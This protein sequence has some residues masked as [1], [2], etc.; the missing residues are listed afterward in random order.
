MKV[1]E[2][3]AFQQIPLFKDT[4]LEEWNDWHWQMQ[5]VISDID[6]L[7]EIID[8]DDQGYADI[9]R[10]LDLFSM[11][12]TP[13][14]AA[15]MNRSDPQC[16]VRMQVVPNVAELESDSEGL[17]DPL[18]E[19]LNSPTPGLIHR[20]PDR[21]LFLLTN[22]CPAY[23]RHCTRR[24]LVGFEN[25][26][27]SR[28]DIDNGISYVREHPEVRDVLLSGGDPLML[29]DESLE[30][31]LTSLR[32]I[33]HVEIIRIGTR[34]PV[35][36]PQRI[37]PELVDMLRKYHPLYVNTQFNHYKE[38]TCETKEACEILTDAGFPL[39]NQSVLL[40]GVNDCPRI[41][42]RLVQ[43]LLM[44]RVK[45][46]YMYQCDLVRGTGHFRTPVARGMEIMENL[47][48]HTSG[49]AVP[50]FVVDAPG[51]CGKIP[52]MPSYLLSC[53]DKQIILRNYEG[54]TTSYPQ[55]VNVYSQCRC[56]LCKGET[57]E[58]ADG[59]AKVLGV[60]D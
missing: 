50:T 30:S 12:I 52:V 44:I 23:C 31:I 6:T 1:F 18:A 10:C 22:A 34:A 8:I 38:I 25:H 51:G 35:V 59:V 32:E 43:E 13:Y 36:L 33:N 5:N 19:D 41:M 46:Y 54:T 16:P 53:S 45:P 15:L 3:V 42:K 4:T 11:H 14:F 26:T 24:R 47:R 27:I 58:P 60:Q 55:P 28:T 7:G 21:V 40:R 20:Y 48:G 2:R 29:P 9:E 39:G 17:V 56:E 37:T 57:Y 49:M